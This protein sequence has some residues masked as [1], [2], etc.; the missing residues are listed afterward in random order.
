[1]FEPHGDTRFSIEGQMLLVELWGPWNAELVDV[2]TRLAAPLMAGLAA[3]GPW[4]VIAIT[5][6]S[7][8]FTDDGADRL[9]A[10]LRQPSPT[11]NRAATAFVI[12]PEVEGYRLCDPLLHEIYDPIAAFAIFESLLPA[13][14]WVDAQIARVAAAGSRERTAS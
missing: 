5:R 3:A 6:V 13:K 12:A 8:M 7:T 4:G 14:T 9:R 2:Y 1:M 10:L 11:L